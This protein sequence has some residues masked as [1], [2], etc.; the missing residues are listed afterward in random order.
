MT[1]MDFA[2]KYYGINLNGMI[3]TDEWADLKE[4]CGIEE[5]DYLLSDRDCVLDAGTPVE[6]V[7]FCG[8]ERFRF[9][10]IPTSGTQ[11]NINFEDADFLDDYEKMDDMEIMS[12][13]EFLESYSYLTEKEY[14]NTVIKY[15]RRLLNEEQ[16]PEDYVS[17]EI[18]EH[19]II[20]KTNGTIFSDFLSFSQAQT[21]VICLI[22]GY[23][24]RANK[25]DEITYKIISILEGLK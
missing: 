8:A 25:V 7:E 1:I 21:Q 23:K 3:T 10:E 5:W 24:L 16:M 17:V 11:I 6:V 12:K 22:E 20:I 14:D 2:K 9:C 4:K 15:F 13:E 19:G 18:G